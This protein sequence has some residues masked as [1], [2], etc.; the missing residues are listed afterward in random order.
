MKTHIRHVNIELTKRCNQRCFYCFNNS[1]GVSRTGE[2]ELDVW[3]GILQHLRSEGLSSVHFTGGEPFLYERIAELLAGAQAIGLSTSVLSNGFRVQELAARVPDV[4]ARLA[5][6]QISLDSM[7]PVIHNRRRGFQEAWN[8][9]VT[10]IHAFRALSVSVEISCVVTEE[11][12]GE[13]AAITRFCDQVGAGLILRPMISQGRGIHYRMSADF[14]NAFA[15]EVES[16]REEGFKN[17]R[18]DRFH[19][20]PAAGDYGKPAPN[21]DIMTLLY[22]GSVRDEYHMLPMQLALVS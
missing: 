20:V 19:Y 18:D 3:L 16:I 8:H 4:L 21:N 5:V 9:A 1:G 17:F 7:S 22:D 11:N 15:R 12:A 6:S 2:L 14:T 10:A 13:L